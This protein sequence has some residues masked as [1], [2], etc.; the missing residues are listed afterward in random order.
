[1]IGRAY[2]WGLAADGQAG[3]ENVL[4]ILRS[5]HRRD[6][7]RPRARLDPRPHAG[8]RPRA[9]GLRAR[10]RLACRRDPRHAER[11]RRPSPVAGEAGR[12]D[13]FS[14][15][16]SGRTEQH[17]PHLPL[18]TDTDIAAALAER[19]AELRP[20]RGRR[21]RRW[22]TARAASTPASRA[23]SRSGRR[24]LELLLV[25]LGRSATG[26]LPARRASSRRTAAT[27]SPLDAR[28][29]AGSAHEGRDVLGWSPRWSGDAHAGRVETSLM[30]ALRPDA[31]RDA[32]PSA[33]NTAPLDRADR[34]RCASTA[35]APSA[36]TACSATRPAPPGRRAAAAR[37]SGRRTSRPRVA[38]RAR[39]GAAVARV[40]RVA[41]VTGAARGIGAATVRALAADGWAVVAVDRCAGRP[42]AALPARHRGGA[43]R[44]GGVGRSGSG[45]R[46]RPFVA[47][48]AT[49]RDD[50][51]RSPLAEERFGGLDA[52]VAAAGVIAGGVPLWELP[53]E[54]EDAVFEVDLRRGR[55]S[56]RGP[57]IPA[58]LRRP[59]P[60][61]GPLHRGRLRGRQ[62]GPPMLAAYCAAKAGV[63]GMSAR[64][65][66]SW[67]APGITANAVSPGSTETP[68][69]DESARLYGARVGG[70]RRRQQPLGRLI[71]PEEVAALCSGSPGRPAAR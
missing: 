60:R 24:P 5:R 18:S 52:I 28:G 30:L 70:G 53:Q 50:A 54:Q 35:S 4:E 66:P 59:E 9:P 31:G 16:R 68:I 48:T 7:A 56:P 51:R 14:S 15:S 10:H 33:G 55:S 47:D 26:H 67:A 1:M 25:E 43:R 8:R 13:A 34:R 21:A 63:T 62:R 36:P 45:R 42:A 17:G 46:P 58:L 71:A 37:R 20:R 40:T 12:A 57:G 69:L 61:A 27:P 44:G 41:L 6:A 3:V 23:R 29:R 11:A 22:R 32:T 49:R 39:D 65:P 2:L 38:V 19:L 64:W